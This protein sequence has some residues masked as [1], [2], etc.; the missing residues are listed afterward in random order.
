MP[1]RPLGGG[2]GWKEGVNESRCLYIIKD[3]EYSVVFGEGS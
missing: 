3:N 1:G 2:R